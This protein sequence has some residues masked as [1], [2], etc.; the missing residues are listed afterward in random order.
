MVFSIFAAPYFSNL[1][2]CCDVRCGDILC[3]LIFRK[4]FQTLSWHVS[5]GC[6][7]A[8]SKIRGLSISLVLNIGRVVLEP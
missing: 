7:K 4:S 5:V 6:Y 3:V 8:R 2:I 1:R